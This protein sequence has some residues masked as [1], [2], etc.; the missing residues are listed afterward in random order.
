MLTREEILARKTAGAATV[1]H[2]L[3]DGS[4][5]VELRGMTVRESNEAGAAGQDRDGGGVTR[6]TVLMLHYGLVSPAMS[7]EDVEAWADVPGQVGVV[8]DI[9]NKIADLSGIRKGAAKSGVPRA[10]KR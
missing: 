2:K 5:E 4:G 6:A 7:V 9:A 1:T 10:A 3:A 8:E